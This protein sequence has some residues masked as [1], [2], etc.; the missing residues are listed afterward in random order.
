PSKIQ[1]KPQEI[2]QT[3]TS[4]SVTASV[5]S[6][7]ANSVSISDTIDGDDDEF[8]FTDSPSLKL[9]IHLRVQPKLLP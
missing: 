8:M 1:H 3:I 6:S 2:D 7:K 5:S 4:S 9:M